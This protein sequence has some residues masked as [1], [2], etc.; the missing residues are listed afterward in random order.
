MAKQK[1]EKIDKTKLLNIVGIGASAG[2]LK[3]L[4]TLFSK[5]PDDTGL[6]F[7][8]VVHLSPDHKSVMAEL[9]QPHIKMPVK[10]VTKTEPLLAN[11]VYIIP[12]NANLNTIDTHLRLTKLEE[13]RRER[14]PIDH[15]FR[16]LS[17]THDGSAVGI[18]LT[19]TGSDG[20]LGLKAIKEKGG[21]TIVQDP[22]DAEFDGMPQSAISTGLVDKVLKLDEIPGYFIKTINTRP[23]LKGLRP[24]EESDEREHSL[25]QK[26]FAQVR[27]RTGR[28]FSRYKISTIMRRLQRRMQLQQEEK[29]ER[30]LEQ[31]REE[32]QEV[33]ALSDEFLINVTSFFRDPAVFQHL[34]D[35]VLPKLFEKQS[36]EDQLRIWSVGCATGEEA[37]S[38]AMLLAEEAA[39]R[40]EPPSIQIFASDLH[41]G[42]LHKAREGFY[43][44]DIE[45]DI[46]AERLRRFFV[47]EDGGYRIRKEL[48]E[49]IIFTPHNLLSDPPFS[50]ID[51][52]VCRNLLIYM[53]REVQRDIFELFHY[54][55]RSEGFVLLGSSEHLDS[56]DLF[57]TENKELSF[58]IKR[59]V[60]GPE[61]R[62]PVFPQLQR[63]FPEE[64]KQQQVDKGSVSY[65]TV[66]QRMVE[67]YGPPSLLLSPDYQVVH[68]SETAGRFLSISGGELSRDAFKLV[69]PALRMELRSV[70]FTA[71]ERGSLVRSKPV[72]LRMDGKDRQVV[73]SAAVR[74][75]SKNESVILVL[76]EEFKNV[77]HKEQG[78][79]AGKG[80]DTMIQNKRMQDLEKDLEEARQRLQAIIEEYETSREEMK[81]SNEEL[82]S[83]NEELRSTMEELETS[84]E[85][86]QSMNEE[87]TTLNQENNHKVDELGRLNDDLQ[88]LLSA[89]D[90][91]TLFLDRELRILRF[92]P[93]LGEL[94]NVRM[95]DRG[96]PISD[97]TNRLGY[98]ELDDDA[99]KV[100][101]HLVPVEREVKDT[102]GNYYFARI[103]PYRS[104]ED[105]IEGVV[106]TFMDISERKGAEIKLRE[107]QDKLNIALEAA[108]MGVWNHDL[109][110]G[111]I[112]STL[113]HNQLFG[114]RDKVKDWSF[115][116][117]QQ[118][119]LKE[120]KQK[121]DD[122]YQHAI[123]TGL[124]DVEYQVGWP[125]GSVH[126]V[127]DRG[128][129]Y[130]G[131]NGDPLRMT[132]VSVETTDK[133]Q[134]SEEHRRNDAFYH[135]IFEKQSVG[136]CLMV[137]VYDKQGKISD[138][139][140]IEHNQAFIKQT[141]IDQA[142]GK[143]YS[144]LK[145]DLNSWTQ[146]FDK[147][148]Q[149]D[150]VETKVEDNTALNR[151]LKLEVVPLSV[152]GK[153]QIAVLVRQL[154]D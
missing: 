58:H 18:I 142:L 54:A 27:A 124:L 90:I 104:S 2:G 145:D 94:F 76:F 121:Y 132:G 152:D 40:D 70:I 114:Y 3:A 4:K 51:L 112:E 148:L 100:L 136:F 127:H 95:V 131:E 50:K 21:V 61:P 16:T 36:T 38:L 11:H 72:S 139:K 133:K 42:S 62:L 83:A 92:T 79:A 25:L 68:V 73:I 31:L 118:R 48:R 33:Q 141:G 122:A 28:D 151:R 87:L 26:V 108:R 93:K 19:G 57:V 32:P 130:Y 45:T 6:A 59:N 39:K 10:Q 85:E 81:A 56:T 65:G 52:I 44:G 144:E 60:T 24:G 96:R 77:T 71:R 34:E 126:W 113:R 116:E 146:L 37:Y 12:P 35:V 64:E 105:R 147:A 91:A 135:L 101:K 74:N 107:S 150:T 13:K 63:R 120:D 69:N 53:K 102:E 80:E 103:L 29:L 143:M 23:K 154:K 20:T 14:A 30:Y 153:Q 97:Q 22:L 106:I 75:E 49:M 55:L 149:D 43:P 119:I 82:Q 140:V 123:E 115:Q 78:N 88:N 47:K 134:L 15:F 5:I 7:V 89:T 41:E 9:L 128:H 138:Y 84:K 125:N 8:I 137:P 117:L 110:T 129:T 46:S 66:H 17:K 1:K 67:Q 86:L 98:S 99:R 109:I 111:K